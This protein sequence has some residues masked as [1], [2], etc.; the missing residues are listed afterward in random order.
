MTPDAGGISGVDAPDEHSGRQIA[1]G[2]RPY[3]KSGSRSK[4]QFDRYGFRD[5]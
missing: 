1:A 4:S 5:R 2:K 3:T